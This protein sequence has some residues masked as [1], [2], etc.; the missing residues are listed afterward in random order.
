[1]I[2][3]L[4]MSPGI[5]RVSSSGPVQGRVTFNGRPLDGGYIVFVPIEGNHDGWA[6]ASIDQDGHYSLDPQ[7][8]RG[9]CGRGQFR[10][11][12]IPSNRTLMAHSSEVAG[13]RQSAGALHQFPG[14]YINWR[15]SGLQ[16]TLG[17][18]SA[19]VEIE[20]KD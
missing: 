10:I 19:R 15:T 2:F 7:W 18:E 17:C 16:V 13:S 5:D 8:H 20:L 6:S 9:S 14:R 12:V 11:G 1:M 4:A 3:A